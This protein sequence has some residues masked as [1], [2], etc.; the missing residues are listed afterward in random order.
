MKLITFSMA[1]L[2]IL[3]LAAMSYGAS[4][5]CEVVKRQGNILIMDCGKRSEGFDEK[6]R[7]KIKTDRDKR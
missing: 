4:A 3:G 5:R 6:S 1:L 7:V 2:M